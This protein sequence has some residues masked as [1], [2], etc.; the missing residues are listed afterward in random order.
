MVLLRGLQPSCTRFNQSLFRNSSR[1]FSSACPDGKAIVVERHG[2][3][4][5]VLKLV[6]VPGRTLKERE[7]CVRMLA[8]PINPSDINRI[9]GVYPVGPPVPA[10]GGNEGVGEVIAVSE[11]VKNLS[12]SDWVIPV[13]AG[14]GTWQTFMIKEETDWCKVRKDVPI[15]YAATTFINPCTALRM[16]EDFVPLNEGDLL[17]QNGATSIVGQCVIQ[18]AH[19]R[20][21]RTANIIRERSDFQEVKQRLEGL[22]AS[23][24]FTE[25]EAVSKEIGDLKGAKLGL[26]CV[27]GSAATAV[28]KL[29]GENGIMVT[30]G[31]MS[32]KPITVSTSAFI[33]K[34]IE[35]KGFWLQKWMSHH[36][37]MDLARMTDY[38][39]GL[40]HEGKLTYQME[41]VPFEEFNTALE[42]SLGKRGSVMKQVLTFA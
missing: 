37:P 34:N 36:S 38:L 39:L 35:L 40:V 17:V 22:G 30:Y 3:P 26:N 1:A 13:R 31:G 4:Q 2:N 10:V 28:M 21:L 7:I 25:N 27:G 14:L 12:V 23:G 9:E 11:G 8:A 19:L 20:G 33:F 16:L 18:L 15:E 42:K 5:E 6:D 24:V 41:K 29:L 32:K